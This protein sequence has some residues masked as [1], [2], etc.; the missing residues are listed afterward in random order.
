M[1][2]AALGMQTHYDDQKGTVAVPQTIS[3]ATA[4]IDALNERLT[5]IRKHV[6]SIADTIGGPR[7]QNGQIKGPNPAPSS[8]VG[9][10]NDGADNAHVILSEV[11]ESLNAI[12]RALG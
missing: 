2:G 5:G 7:P 12:T 10:L 8:A 4:R 9:R 3:S 11:E 6:E 1:Q